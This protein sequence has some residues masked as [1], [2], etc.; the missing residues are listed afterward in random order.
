MT[1]IKDWETFVRSSRNFFDANRGSQIFQLIRKLDELYRVAH[2]KAPFSK[3]GGEGDDLFRKCFV[4]CH[5]ALLSAATNTGSG[6]PED[7]PAM[8][9]RAFEAAKVCLAV[10]AHPDNFEAWKATEARRE[11]WEARV[12]GAKPKPLNPRYKG[13]SADPFYQE[14]QSVIGVLSDAAVHFT[15]EHFGLYEWDQMLNPDGTADVTLGIG[16]NTVAYRFF[17]LVSQHLLIIRVFDRC[18]DG[19]LIKDADVKRATHE[20]VDL[21]VQLNRQEGLAEPARMIEREWSFLLT[22]TC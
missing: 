1:Y 5:W 6:L 3:T 19:E 13:V 11:R 15:P 14:I 4:T 17:E 22:S 18:L 2:R 16:E 21:L 20:V 9:R 10:K 7:G 8:I 12:S